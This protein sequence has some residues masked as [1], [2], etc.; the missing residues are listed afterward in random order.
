VTGAAEAV[1]L[2][3]PQLAEVLGVIGAHHPVKPVAKAARR[4]LMKHRSR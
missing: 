1:Q 3:H 4:A 2:D